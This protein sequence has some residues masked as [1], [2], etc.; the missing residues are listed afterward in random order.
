M[1][2]LEREMGDDFQEVMDAIRQSIGGILLKLERESQRLAPSEVARLAHSLKS[3]CATIG[4][5]PLSE[6]ASDFENAADQGNVKD[7]QA[8]LAGLRQ[9]Y[10]RVLSLLSER[11]F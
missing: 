2:R 9:E 8:R 7:F 6:M 4:A 10:R 5:N 11:G 3:P 1:E